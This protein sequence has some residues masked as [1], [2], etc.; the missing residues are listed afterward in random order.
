M[1]PKQR[2]CLMRA[3]DIPPDHDPREPTVTIQCGNH[4]IEVGYCAKHGTGSGKIVSITGV[5]KSLYG[6]IDELLIKE[7]KN[8]LN[9]IEGHKNLLEG[10]IKDIEEQT[11]DA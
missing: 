9:L 6:A 4:S 2:L 8:Q 1:T 7:A 11:N 5:P 10:F 3:L